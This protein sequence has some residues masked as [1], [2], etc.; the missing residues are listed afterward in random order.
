M[1]H[2]SQ[3]KAKNI[4]SW[5]NLVLEFS[6]KT[7]YS[8]IGHNG[9]GKSSVFEI[10]KWVLFKKTAKKTV[11]R[12]GTKGDGEAWI[13]LKNESGVELT[14][15][16]RASN[17][18]TIILNEEENTQEH[19]EDILGCSYLGFMSSIMCDQKRTSSFIGEKTAAGKSKIF[20]DMIGASILDKMRE[21]SQK[22]KNEK[23]K[24]YLTLKSKVDTLSTELEEVVL[25][26]DEMSPK[27]F[28]SHVRER[29]TKVKLY[30]VQS[31][32]ISFKYQEA[33]S[34]NQDW[35]QYEESLELK[36]KLTKELKVIKANFQVASK[37]YSKEKVKELRGRLPRLEKA[38][39]SL[40]E[41]NNEILVKAKVEK[42]KCEELE[43]TL[44]SFYEDS[45]GLCPTCG[46]EWKEPQIQS[47]KIKKKIQSH[48]NSIKKLVTEMNPYGDKMKGLNETIIEVQ[49]KIESM[50]EAKKDAE[51]IKNTFLSKKDT[52]SYIDRP[53]PI[54]AKVDDVELREKMNNINSTIFN[55]NKEISEKKAI[56]KSY[57]NLAGK[58]KAAKEGLKKVEKHYTLYKWMF[59]NLP[60][61]KL[62]FI[63]QNKVAVENF[64]NE[65]LSKMGLPFVVK[66]NTQREMSKGKRIKDE[67]SFKILN[68]HASQEAHR[69]DL[70]GGEEVCVLLATQFAINQVSRTNIGFEIYDEIYGPLDKKNKAVIIDSLLDRGQKKQILSVSHDDEI[71]NSFDSVI[72]VFKNNGISRVKGQVYGTE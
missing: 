34:I 33:L 52:L 29:I 14:I 53:K 20:G 55:M 60:I 63:D 54:K 67:F 25:N 16:R 61:M 51:S 68:V 4:F 13:T 38:Y 57:K 6:D 32:E 64:I 50:E 48:K 45:S 31:Q 56:L 62:R 9:S 23:E 42:S 66:I 24:D 19:L 44:H 30:D 69:E 5:E 15:N 11:K 35:K 8:I 59:D 36:K 7:V 43:E 65:E 26:F 1:W 18:A 47:K 71:S 41:A 46:Q 21:K 28:L 40:E 49:D 72:S 58:L 17:P 2:I 37:A 39:S 10:I 3:I 70:S 22:L 27:E 12:Y